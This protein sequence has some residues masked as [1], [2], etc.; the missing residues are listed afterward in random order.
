MLRDCLKFLLPLF[1]C[2]LS[3]PLLAQAQLSPKIDLTQQQDY[4]LKRVSSSDPS[5][6]NADFRRVDPGGVLT[7]MDANGPGMLTHIWIT[8]ASP[9]ADH[10][11]KLVLRIYWDHETTPSVEAPL[12]DFFG[13][14]LGE[15]HRWESELLSVGSDKALNSFFFMPFQN[16]ARITVSNEGQQKVDAFYFNLDYRA[17]SESLPRGTLY[18][19]A[20][21]RQAQPNH[22]WTS[23]WQNNGDPKV[24]RKTNLD[25]KENYFWL[26]ATGRGHFVGVTMSVLQ[27]QDGWWGEGDDMFFIDGEARPSIA[28]TGSEDYFLGAWDFGGHP[29]FYRLYGAP[30][31]GEERAGGKSSVYRFHLDSPITFTKSIRATI[32]HGHANHR[33]DNFY[34]VAYWYQ[35]EPHATFPVLPSVDQRIPRPQQVGGPGNAAVVHP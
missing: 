20:Q 13:L 31:V 18:F 28:G 5:G 25:G 2:V 14:G 21:F 34:S 29:F 33:S 10:L 4:V 17:Y 19:H 22:G 26:D 30:V 7:L 11:K 16:H 15:Y 9:E 8:V 6:A 35:S 3:Q 23:D 24:D 1:G 32:E 12:G 27:N